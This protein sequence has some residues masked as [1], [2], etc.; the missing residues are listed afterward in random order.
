MI[1]VSASELEVAIK[2]VRHAAATDKGRPIL[3]TILFE[4]RDRTTIRV[5]AADNYRIAI[6]DVRAVDDDGHDGNDAM[7]IGRSPVDVVDLRLL[8]PFLAMTR[9]R[10]L[11]LSVADGRLRVDDGFRSI[12]LRVVDGAYPKYEDVVDMYEPKAVSVA[13]RPEFVADVGKALGAHAAFMKLRFGGPFDPVFVDG[14]D[15]YR[16]IIMPVRTASEDKA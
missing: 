11:K 3:A 1:T 13:V 7:A 8:M 10:T 16:E 5:V 6:Q 15:G 14:V 2:R 12:D 4:G 9:K